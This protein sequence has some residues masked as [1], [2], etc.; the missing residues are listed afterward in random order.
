[1]GPDPCEICT[2]PRRASL[3]ACRL[4]PV[5]EGPIGIL[6]SV[7]RD[8]AKPVASSRRVRHSTSPAP[9]TDGPTG[10]PVS[11]PWGPTKPTPLLE[12]RF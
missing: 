7:P 8:P 6:V 12:V 9:N 10:T 11:I 3:A 4:H 2:L 1:M 5:Q